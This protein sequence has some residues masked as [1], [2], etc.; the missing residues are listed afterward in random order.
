MTLS[1]KNAKMANKKSRQPLT[2]I[3]APGLKISAQYDTIASP[4]EGATLM[5]E[6]I[7]PN[8]RP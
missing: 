4:T 1:L 3:T 7:T 2:D 8:T 6:L 5:I